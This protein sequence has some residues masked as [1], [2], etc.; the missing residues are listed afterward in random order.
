MSPRGGRK[1]VISIIRGDRKQLPRI[2]MRKNLA[3]CRKSCN[4]AAQK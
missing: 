4:F 3:V 2:F 1:D